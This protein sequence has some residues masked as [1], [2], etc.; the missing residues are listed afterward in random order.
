LIG[1]NNKGN[2]L[3]T[4]SGIKGKASSMNLSKGV[5]TDQ[6]NRSEGTLISTEVS[7][8][9]MANY[10]SK[11]PSGFRAHFFGFEIVNQILNQSGCIGIRMCYALNNSGVQQ[12]LLV[13]V[14]SNGEN[15]LP[16][17][18]VA[19]KVSGDGGIIGDASFPCPTY[20]SGGG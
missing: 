20:C 3:L 2:D 18:Q 11:N 13:G 7:R 10:T 1:A 19:G 17:T 16:T 8:Q 4:A 6:L 12:I 15:I 5:A 14:S 9:W